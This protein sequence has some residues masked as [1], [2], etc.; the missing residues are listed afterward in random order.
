MLV[1]PGYADYAS[2]F[3]DVLS[4]LREYSWV[5]NFPVTELLVQDVFKKIPEDWLTALLS[6]TNQ[7]LNILPQG[8]VMV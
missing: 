8:F 1:P 3:S 6:L 7:Q 2:Y 5:Y 4:F